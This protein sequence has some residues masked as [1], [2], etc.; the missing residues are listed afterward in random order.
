MKFQQ[1]ID[2]YNK[3]VSNSWKLYL[4]DKIKNYDDVLNIRDFFKITRK[5]KDVIKRFIR[6]KYKID[7][8]NV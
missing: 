6:I 1:L 3:S 2:D 5:N 8:I 4:W 7:F